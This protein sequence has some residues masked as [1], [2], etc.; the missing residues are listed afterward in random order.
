MQ[1]FLQFLRSLP[2]EWHFDL[3]SSIVTLVLIPLALLV[4]RIASRALRVWAQYAIDGI[5]YWLSRSIMHSLASGLSLS[6]YCRLQLDSDSR[7]L[8]VPSRF[9]TKLEVDKVFVTLTLEHHGS[10]KRDFT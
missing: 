4:L 10:A 7:F 3:F 5:M 9:D 1:T 2:Q 6:K 8:H